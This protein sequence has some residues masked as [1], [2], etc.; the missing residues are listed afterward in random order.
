[1]FARA[2]ERQKEMGIRTAVGAPRRRL[3]RQLLTES[4]L[5]AVLAGGV[6]VALSFAGAPLLAQFTPKGDIPV[7]PDERWQWLPMFYTA[8]AALLAG[9]ISGLAPA[10]RATR[11]DVQSVL[12]GAGTGAGRARHFFRSGLVLSQ[13]AICVVVLVCGGLFV[14]SLRTVAGHELGFRPERL[15]MASL[16]LGLQGYEPDRGRRFLDQL[17]ERI[18]AVPGVEAAAI[19]SIVPFD[20]TFGLR[21]VTPAER[22]ATSKPGNDDAIRAGVN[23]IDPAY[24]RA[25]GVALLQGR[26]FAV[27]DDAAAPRVALVNQTL[28]NRLW[29]GQDPLGRRFRWLEG[30]DAIEVVGVVRDGKYVML[31][32]APRPY[33]YLPLAQEYDTPVTL[34]VRAATDDPLVLV[35]AIRQVLNDL[36]PDLPI[37][38]VRTMPE[39]LRN[40]AMALLP[41]RMGATLAGVQGALALLLAVMGLYGVVAYAVSQQ[42]RE[43]GIRIALG[44]RGRDLFRVVAGGGLRPAMIGLVAG[45]LVSLG[46]AR[47]L[48]GLLYGL[49]PL[50]LPVFTAVIALLL[51]VSLFACWLP[52]RRVLKVD[53]VIALRSE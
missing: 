45:V 31:G 39:H 13:V 27:E 44:A 37:F 38:S 14:R 4:V 22:P 41:L 24:L 48:A 2:L 51:G 35:P 52:A 49:N 20:N 42:R 30:N 12:K 19:A 34:H 47:L 28:A 16:D 21:E 50:D 18:Q 3:I 32:E 8:A 40:S 7:R 11:V 43:I 9:V 6:G 33:L 17:T 15:L 10:L 25:M 5:L 1:M 46:L 29:P 23:R 53:P 26:E 36:D